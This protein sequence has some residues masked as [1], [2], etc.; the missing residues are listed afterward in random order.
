MAGSIRIQRVSTASW[1]SVPARRGAL[2]DK[3]VTNQ[4][5][6]SVRWRV[7]PSASSA[8]PGSVVDPSKTASTSPADLACA[9]AITPAL[10]AR[11]STAVWAVIAATVQ[12]R[13]S[14][15][16]GSSSPAIATSIAAFNTA[17]LVPNSNSTVGTEISA[18]AAIDTIVVPAYP[19]A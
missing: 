7:I 13:S 5:A 14:T 12:S 8:N 16:T 10:M 1:M 19:T 3:A 2:A 15:G 18:P 17:A 6:V 11:N 4:V 9:A